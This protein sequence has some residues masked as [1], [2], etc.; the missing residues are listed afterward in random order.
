MLSVFIQEVTTAYNGVDA[1]DMR[2]TGYQFAHTDVAW[3][4]G[5]RRGWEYALAATRPERHQKSGAPQVGVTSTRTKSMN[6]W[7]PT[8]QPFTTIERPHRQAGGRGT[9]VIATSYC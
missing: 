6:T 3:D 7:S 8:T 9:S 2:P 4:V 5:R 1:A